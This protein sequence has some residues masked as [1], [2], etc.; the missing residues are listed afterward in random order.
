VE[1]ESI[2]GEDLWILHVRNSAPKEYS[3]LIR[4]EDI[5]S[6]P[7]IVPISIGRNSSGI[8]ILIYLRQQD[9][10]NKYI[11]FLIEEECLRTIR[12]KI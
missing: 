3:T 4:R 10:N 2:L 7:D 9:W 8:F 12:S 6:L 5:D 11:S 1:V